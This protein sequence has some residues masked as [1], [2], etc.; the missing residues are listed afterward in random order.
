MSLLLCTR[1]V[2]YS[3]ANTTPAYSLLHTSVLSLFPQG[4]EMAGEVKET[5]HVS[6]MLY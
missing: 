6:L 2:Y 1:L 5:L 4:M 3:G